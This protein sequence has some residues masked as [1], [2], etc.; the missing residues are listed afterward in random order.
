MLGKRLNLHIYPSP[1]KF[2]TRITKEVY[3]IL[4]MNL[5]D[6][7]IICG[8][9]EKKLLK[10][11]YIHK[12]IRVVR[13][14]TGLEKFRRNIFTAMLSSI[15]FNIKCFIKF[16]KE[17]LSYINCHSLWVLPLSVYIK[18]KT[19]A[20][21]IYDAHELETERAA[22]K[23]IKQKIAKYLEK[24]FIRRANSIIVV[25][26]LIA[27]WYKKKYNRTDVYVIKNVPLKNSVQLSNTKTDIFRNK[28]NIPSDHIIFIYQGLINY[29][30]GIDIMLDAFTKVKDDKHLVVMGYGP[31]ANRVKIAAKSIKNIHFHEAVKPQEIPLYTSVADCGVCVAENVGLS[32]YWGLPN[33]F[34]EYVYNGLPII[35]SNFPEMASIVKKYSCGWTIKP[36]VDELISLI[37]NISFEDIKFKKQN[38][39]LIK[40]DYNWEK[41]AKNL[42]K[43]FLA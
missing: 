38:L 11:E 30:R 12:N 3:S 19:K 36:D 1:F 29:G 35:T 39:G 15:I 10:E 23:G 32:Y 9:W 4:A 26:E 2:E 21:L 33:K 37:N 43:A 17:E 42:M 13:I 22:L 20:K 24:K 14:S 25:G 5:V 6:E 7:I 31:Y 41:E 18:K 8:T 34:F 27:D 28:F 40:E 16:S